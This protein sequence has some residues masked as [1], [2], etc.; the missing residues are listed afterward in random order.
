[1]TSVIETPHLNPI[2]KNGERRIA[3][4]V[5]RLIQNSTITSAAAIRLSLS[6]RERIEVR[7]Y[8][9]RVSQSRPKS[10][11]TRE[12]SIAQVPPKNAFPFGRVLAQ[13]M[14]MTHKTFNYLAF[15]RKGVSAP[16]LN[17][18]PT[19]GE[20][21]ERRAAN[22]VTCH[23]ARFAV[24]LLAFQISEDREKR[25]A[26]PIT[27]LAMRMAL[28]VRLFLSQRDMMKERDCFP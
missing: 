22:S 1:M 9:L 13:V 11:L 8:F 14:S 16:H 12:I 26:V 10:Q 4:H 21:R 23:H 20:R 24:P 25:K 2:P 15:F 27:A 6:Q 7:D 5:A 17:P 18:L 28:V 3:H 19:I